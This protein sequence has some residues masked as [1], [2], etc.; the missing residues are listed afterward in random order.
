[1]MSYFQDDSMTSTCHLLLH[2][3]YCLPATH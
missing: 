2:M 3:Q 1:M